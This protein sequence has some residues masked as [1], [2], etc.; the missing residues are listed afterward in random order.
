VVNILVSL[1]LHTLE[2]SKQVSFGCVFR[3]LPNLPRLEPEGFA[4]KL[5][6]NWSLQAVQVWPASGMQGSDLCSWLEMD[7]YHVSK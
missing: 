2:V 3:S 1:L 7:W 5:G 4:G 6:T